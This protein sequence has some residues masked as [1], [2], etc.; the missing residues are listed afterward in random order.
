VRERERERGL[1]EEE[2]KMEE[3][4]MEPQEETMRD[5]ARGWLGA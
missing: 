1:S 4:F 2:N 3:R 5:G